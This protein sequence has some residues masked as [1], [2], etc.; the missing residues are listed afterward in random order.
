MIVWRICKKSRAASAFD[1]EGARIYPGRWNHKGVPMVYCASSLPLA[2]LEY[3][4]H[5]DPDD[6]PDDL[7]AISADVLE[8]FPRGYVDTETLPSGWDQ[9]PSPVELKD[10]GTAWVKKGHDLALVVPS[11]II[12]TEQNVLLNP[13]HEDMVNLPMRPPR[14]FTFDPRMRK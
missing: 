13:Q 12:P 7:V 3:F 2:A 11:A 10:L 1:G 8:I 5:L 9:V 4:V 14:P 6:W